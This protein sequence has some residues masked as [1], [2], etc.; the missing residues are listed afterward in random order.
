MAGNSKIHI[1]LVD[2]RP[3]NLQTIEAILAM[4]EYNFIK[5]GSGEEAKS[6]LQRYDFA[7]IVLSGQIPGA[8]G[9]EIAKW[10]RAQDRTRN[11]PI[12]FVADYAPD[13]KEVFD[14]YP[15]GIV[16]CVLKPL[17]PL[18]LQAK[19]AGF[20]EIFRLN[21]RLIRQ[22]E[23][24]AEKT[25]ELDFAYSRLQESEA[26]V[27]AIS[28]TTMDSVL[29][30]DGTGCILKANPAAKALFQY[31]ESEILGKDL[32]RLFACRQAGKAIGELL[33][34]V[35]NKDGKSTGCKMEGLIARR[36]DGSQF[37]CELQMGVKHAGDRDVI[38]CVIRD[39]TR[40]SKAEEKIRHMAYHDGL[41]D[42]PNRRYFLE[43]L[44]TGLEQ[45]KK[46][47]R[48][49]VLMSLDMD[50]FKY[51]NDSLGHQV[52]DKLL[53]KFAGRL[54]ESLR[55]GDFVSRN[56]G[57]E[58]SILLFDTDLE[59]A[60][61]IAERVLEGIQKP[62]E[63]DEYELNVT[64]SIGIS[65]YPYDGE[66]ATALMK[67]ADTALYHAKG[68]GKD[69][70]K[71]YHSGMSLKAYRAFMLKKDLCRAIKRREL[72]LLYQPRFDI[73]TGRI[74]SVEALLRWRHPRLGLISPEEFIPLA[75]ESGQIIEIGEWVLRSACRQNKAWLR[76]GLPPVRIGVNFSAHQF[77]QKDLVGTI[78]QIIHETDLEPDMVEIEITEA[79]ILK[80][81]QRAV[82]TLKQIQ[83]MGI[84]I[85]I[86]DFGIGCSPLNYLRRYPI[87]TVKIDRSFIQEI[88]YMDPGSASLISAIAELSHYMD[89]TVVAE[90]VETPEQLNIIKSGNCDEI[91]GYL[92]SPPVP[93]EEMEG[94]LRDSPLRMDKMET[95]SSR[96]LPVL[97]TF[98]SFD[99][100]DNQEIID[101]AIGRI[102]KSYF[103]TARETEVFRLLVGGLTNKEISKALHIDEQKVRE[104]I[105]SVF[106]KVHVGDRIPA[107]GK[108]YQAY[109]E[110][111]NE[112]QRKERKEPE[113]V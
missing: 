62:F 21:R 13:L 109:I 32:C 9:F 52:G 5:A 34:S 26:L 77:M 80:N 47:G 7:A 64:A 36:K 56:G 82:S 35:K 99:E 106:Q 71:I 68:R 102:Q 46:H 61:E 76:A 94:L 88:S 91:Q 58:F 59:T 40:K 65:V 27:H 23:L 97:S 90:G 51:I 101:R 3:E 55:E 48:S 17:N 95:S 74:T 96:D 69:R 24:L 73:R 66:D 57:D 79:V 28:E 110:E 25:R 98:E 42:L 67:I 85:C 63:V 105:L 87:N 39:M 18:V 83:D 89:I 41:T 29:V 60:V 103:L 113:H 49:L 2:D 4:D 12:L 30:L 72:F 107:I 108:V 92:S 44:Y 45:A 22:A 93:A 16:D 15:A 70:Y 38:V 54:K 37:P 112:W 6:C 50:G 53:Q 11:I 8:D 104:H 43:K 111:K 31:E 33:L 20:V 100:Q 78:S 84:G 14:P 86:D 10:I 81:E 75:E 19:V 1:L